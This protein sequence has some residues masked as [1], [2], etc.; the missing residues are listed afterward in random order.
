MTS[1]YPFGVLALPAIIVLLILAALVM[2]DSPPGAFVRDSI[3]G[4]LPA[5]APALRAAAASCARSL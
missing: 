5:G 3:L 1:W 4:R 2:P